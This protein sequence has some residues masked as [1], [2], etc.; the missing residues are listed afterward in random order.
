MFFQ[1]FTTVLVGQSQR[2]SDALDANVENNIKYELD[3]YIPL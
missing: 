1:P 3:S 2:V